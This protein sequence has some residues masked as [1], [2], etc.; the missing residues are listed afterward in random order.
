MSESII[1]VSIGVG[2]VMGAMAYM[3][4]QFAR[5]WTNIANQDQEYADAQRFTVREVMRGK[6]IDIPKLRAEEKILK[7][8][9]FIEALHDEIMLKYFKKNN[10]GK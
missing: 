3:I 8:N 6:G 4:Y 1:F 7:K 9:K 5:I 2:L 10:G